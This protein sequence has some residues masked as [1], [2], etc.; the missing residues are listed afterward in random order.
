MNWVLGLERY[1]EKYT[2]WLYHLANIYGVC[3]GILQ[4]QD[5]EKVQYFHHLDMQYIDMREGECM[6]VLV[7]AIK[8]N[9]SLSSLS[10]LLM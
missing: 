10:A 1:W 6:N 2:K 5:S 3:K 7:D 4:E 8:A 9:D